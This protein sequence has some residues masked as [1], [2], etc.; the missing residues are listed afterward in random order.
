M[1]VSF[2]ANDCICFPIVFWESTIQL[3]MLG[4]QNSSIIELKYVEIIFAH[5]DCNI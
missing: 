1:G 5:L 4:V 3:Y 2:H